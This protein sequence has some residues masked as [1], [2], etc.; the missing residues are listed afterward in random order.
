[1]TV[2]KVVGNPSSGAMQALEPHIAS[3]Y[4]RPGVHLMAIVEMVHVERIQPAPGADGKPTVKMKIISCEVPSEEQEGAI[5]TAQRALYLART[6][7]GTLDEDGQ[8]QLDEDT[9]KR[10]AGELLWIECAQ[11]RAGLRHWTNYAQ[12]ISGASAQFSTTEMAHELKAVADGLTSIVQQA[13][14]RGED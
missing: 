12:R 3:L 2:L 11:L 1:V 13:D 9:L 5:R 10:T 4:D 7:R 8:L 14:A 6:A